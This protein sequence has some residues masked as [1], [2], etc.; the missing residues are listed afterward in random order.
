MALIGIIISA[1]GGIGVIGYSNLVVSG[2]SMYEYWFFIITRV[3]LYLFAGGL[4]LA[5]ISLTRFPRKR[6]K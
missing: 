5:M 1:I 2:Y 6:K 3:E 4:L